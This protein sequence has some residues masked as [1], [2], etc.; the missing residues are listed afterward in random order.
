MPADHRRRLGAD[1]EA[2]AA[3]WY[4][5]RGYVVLERNWR[6]RE[7]ELDL[8]LANGATIVFCEVKTRTSTR[9]GVPAEAVTVAKQRRIRMLAARY[10]A[11]SPHRRASVRFDVVAVL[12]RKI[13]V[14]EAAF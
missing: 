4:E 10:L 13:D 6:C 12:G 8:V 14:I 5:A 11:A 7:G 3:A 9:F 1:G 2:Q